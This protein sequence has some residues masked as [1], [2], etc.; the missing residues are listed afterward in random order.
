MPSLLSAFTTDQIVGELADRCHAVL[1]AFV[2]KVHAEG[3]NQEGVSQFAS[4]GALRDN[5]FLLMTLQELVRHRLSQQ[6]AFDGDAP[7]EPR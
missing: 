6:N 1:I 3:A 2:P 4:T 7:G 5:A